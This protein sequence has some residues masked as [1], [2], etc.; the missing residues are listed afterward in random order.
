MY[1]YIYINRT[2]GFSIIYTP[3]TVGKRS[4][5]IDKENLCG[6]SVPTK[7][8][9]TPL[10]TSLWPSLIEAIFSSIH[11]P[12]LGECISRMEAYV[13][14]DKKQSLSCGFQPLWKVWIIMGPSSP[15]SG[16]NSPNK[17]YPLA[18]EIQ[19]TSNIRIFCF[20]TVRGNDTAH[21]IVYTISPCY[22]D[23]SLTRRVNEFGSSNPGFTKYINMFQKKWQV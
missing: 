13:R 6:P 18:F 3:I 17:L 2:C 11:A 16:R 9:E 22:N 5:I 14:D 15:N 21:A 4:E 1:I 23:M 20:L 8:E 12:S 19:N 10:S 7:R